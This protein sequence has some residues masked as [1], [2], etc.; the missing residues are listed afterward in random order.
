VTKQEVTILVR[1]SL[2]R[3][4]N[5]KLV[6]S[7]DNNCAGLGNQ[8]CDVVLVKGVLTWENHKGSGFLNGKQMGNK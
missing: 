6:K 7:I 8:S 5:R 4:V 2:K 3:P 1:L